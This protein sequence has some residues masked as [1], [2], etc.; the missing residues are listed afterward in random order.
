MS[1]RY[2]GRIRV[3]FRDFDDSAYSVGLV[4]LDPIVL[5]DNTTFKKNTAS[6]EVDSYGEDDWGWQE[7][8]PD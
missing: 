2:P 6:S 8:A 5:P 7:N 3:F 1:K 4:F